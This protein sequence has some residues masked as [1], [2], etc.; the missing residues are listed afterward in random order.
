MGPRRVRLRALRRL[1]HAVFADDVQ[2]ASQAGRAAEIAA[3]QKAALKPQIPELALELPRGAPSGTVVRRD[4]TVLTQASLGISLPVDPMEHV[5][6][7]EAPGGPVTEARVKLEKGEKKRLTLVVKPASKASSAPVIVSA[8]AMERRS[9]FLTVTGLV[10]TPIGSIAAVVGVV[11]LSG[12]ESKPVGAAL[13]VSGLVFLGGGITAFLVGSQNVP[14]KQNA[15]GKQRK[16]A[17]WSPTVEI[18]LTSGALR[19]TF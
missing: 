12:N 14:V 5:I 9:T 15:P 13:L 4:G 16:A 19:W 11:A 6:T 8:P 2:P 18:G 1:P 17:G 7:T 10:V 3:A